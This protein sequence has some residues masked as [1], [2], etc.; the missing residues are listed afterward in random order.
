MARWICC[1]LLFSRRKI[2]VLL[3]YREHGV[4][5]R[6]LL[7]F[8]LRQYISMVS[9]IFIKQGVTTVWGGVREEM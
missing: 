2:F 9:Q 1:G 3:F 4:I 5:K 7:L 6:L 8:L